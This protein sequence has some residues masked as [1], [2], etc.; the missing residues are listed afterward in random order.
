MKLGLMTLYVVFMMTQFFYLGKE[1][2]HR[3]KI[4][5]M[6]NSSLDRVVYRVL[7]GMSIMVFYFNFL[8][9]L[10]GKWIY[11]A[12]WI[13]WALLGLFY[14]W[15]TR[16]KIIQ[17]SV[18]S[19]F[20]EFRY[21]DAFEK[22]IFCLCILFLIFSIPMFPILTDIEALKLLTDPTEKVSPYFWNFFNV[23][24]YPFKKYTLLMKIAFLVHFYIFGVAFSMLSLYALLRYFVSR[25]LSILGA[26]VYISTWPLY[27]MYV[28]SISGIISQTFIISWVW[29]IFWISKSS[30][31]R[32]G[33]FLGL[34]ALLATLLNHFYFYLIIPSSLLIFVLFIPD[35]TIWYKR[36]LLKYASF[37]FIASAVVY[38]MGFDKFG[39]KTFSENL[40]VI[41]VLSKAFY[42]L[43]YFGVAIFLLK[44]L[45]TKSKLLN[46]FL[47]DKLKLKATLIIISFFILFAILIDASYMEPMAII[48]F[49]VL[50]SL[51]PL[52]LLF[53]NIARLRSK[54]NMI[55]LVYIIICLLDSHLEGRIK[56][57]LAI[58]KSRII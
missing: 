32:S 36:Q 33:L 29:A 2:D 21:L 51:I 46:S 54:R 47:I 40:S 53:Q 9:L 25:R 41:H 30:T 5:F 13:T 58:L 14:S 52:E 42:S 44:I 19:N 57:F 37:G 12:F 38:Y 26:F 1:L 6:V 17:E 45:N 56:I 7:S 3:L 16:G 23:L 20:S 28:N 50:L 35:K 27:K 34:I 18:T 15:P 11:N 49:I 24:Y 31:Y 55:Y 8:N 48:W 4:Y 10:P 22:T 39:G 43:T